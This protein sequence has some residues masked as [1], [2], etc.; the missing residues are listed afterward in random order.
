M[1]GN[2]S[3]LI[4]YFLI[5][6]VISFNYFFSR[7]NYILY[8]TI[9][10]LVPTWEWLNNIRELKNLSR[11]AETEELKKKCKLVLTGL[12]ISFCSM[13]AGFILGVIFW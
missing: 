4:E 9:W 7:M 5:A 8:G 2:F 6:S 12:C 10:Q 13:L 11:S 3:R 1:D